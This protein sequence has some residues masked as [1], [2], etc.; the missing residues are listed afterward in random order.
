LD[1]DQAAG[2]AAFE[3]F[4]TLQSEAQ[5]Q[6][7]SS[8]DQ[9]TTICHADREVSAAEERLAAGNIAGAAAG[10]QAALDLSPGHA[11]ALAGLAQTH[12]LQGDAPGALAT[13]GQATEAYPAYAEAWSRRGLY[14]LVSGDDAKRDEAYGRFLEMIAQR[15]AQ[16]R[17]AL[18]SRAIADLDRLVGEQPQ[19]APA[20]LEMLPRFR[21]FLDTID[22]A[23]DTYQYPRLYSDLARVALL[24]GDAPLAE[25]LLRH[26]LTIDDRQP[27]AETR[28]ALTVLVQGRDASSEI[29]SL[30]EEINDPLWE[31]SVS[32]DSF[33]RTDL[34]EMAAAEIAG[35]LAAHPDHTDAVAPLTDT[36]EGQGP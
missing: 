2:Q 21:S 16:E 11:G 8:G 30:I 29:S 22:D 7:A 17:L 10:Y 6:W 5:Q 14:A 23:S 9:A 4:A 28:L 26:S 15:P 18:T 27:L 35:Y 25:D 31:E 13:V 24:A 36:I 33:G 3:Q 12:Y 20:M 19:H 32:F 1:Q 34:L